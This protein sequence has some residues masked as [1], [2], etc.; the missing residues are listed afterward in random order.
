[1][2]KKSYLAKKSIQHFTVERELL[3]SKKILPS[4][5]L[6]YAFIKSYARFRTNDTEISFSELIDRT[7]YSRRSVSKALISL[8]ENGFLSL[9]E[10]ES[11]TN[12]YNFPMKY[13]TPCD[14]A[15][16]FLS[17]TS[18]SKKEKEFLLILNPY[19]SEKMTI[20]KFESPATIANLAKKINLSYMTVQ[21]RV[22]TLTAKG[23]MKEEFEVVNVYGDKEFIGYFLDIFKIINKN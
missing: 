13:R 15:F 7:G 4:H 1:M 18:I 11:N 20:G 5:K 17:S 23:I 19:F 22:K 16:G 10:T 6:V 21:D 8:K 12:V 9:S 14:V 2:K 3:I